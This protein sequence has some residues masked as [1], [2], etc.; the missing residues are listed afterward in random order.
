MITP[1][2]TAYRWS[3]PYVLKFLL[4]CFLVQMLN[5][6]FLDRLVMDLDFV[7]AILISR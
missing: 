5:C 7:T 1:G 3:L 6:V 4:Y 2:K